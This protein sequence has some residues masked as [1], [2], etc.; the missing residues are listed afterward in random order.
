MAWEASSAGVEALGVRRAIIRTGVVISR[1]GGA[2]PRMLLPFRLFLGGRLGNGRQWFPW[3]HMADE[4]GAIR[5]LIDNEAANGPFNLT[6][7]NPVSNADFSR[8]VGRQLRRPTFMSI[9]AFVL[10]LL[11]G[12]MATVL[13]DG[14]RAAPQRL[15]QLGF[16]FRFPQAHFA[17]QDVL[18]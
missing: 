11:F 17:L 3:I 9:P 4:V 5:F 13:L 18:R 2:L 16:T 6:A 1:E 10:R 8:M 14:Q 7:P 15:L 12:E